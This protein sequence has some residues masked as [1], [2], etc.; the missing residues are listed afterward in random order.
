MSEC[1]VA[2]AEVRSLQEL[3]QDHLMVQMAAADLLQLHY[4]FQLD[5]C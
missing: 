5:N 2:V 1:V 4:C 3:Q